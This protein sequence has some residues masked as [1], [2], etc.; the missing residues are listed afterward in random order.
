MKNN[1]ITGNEKKY[2]TAKKYFDRTRFNLIRQKLECPEIQNLDVR[3]V[4]KF[5]VKF[6]AEKLK[7]PVIRLVWA[8]HSIAFSGANQQ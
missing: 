7:M 2:L 6:M 8:G 4:V 3:E 5:S 1:D